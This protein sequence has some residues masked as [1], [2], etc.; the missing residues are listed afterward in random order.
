M[1]KSEKTQADPS[2]AEKKADAEGAE[3]SVEEL[4]TVAG[5]VLTM[6]NLQGG[7]LTS[8][9]QAQMTPTVTVDTSLPGTGGNLL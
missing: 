9:K 6:A 2:K 4:E 8:I 7:S 3:L 5:G 1:S